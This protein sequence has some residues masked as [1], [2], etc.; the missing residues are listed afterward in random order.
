MS[1]SD[2]RLQPGSLAGSATATATR[3]SRLSDWLNP[4]L[5]REVKQAVK[6]R[7]FPVTVMLA[8][9]ISAGIKQK[10]VGGAAP[11]QRIFQFESEPLR[12]Q[13]PQAS[14]S[15]IDGQADHLP[16]RCCR[17]LEVGCRH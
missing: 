11:F 3:W 14:E 4:I 10:T 15:V 16:G 8:L 13:P 1:A 6:G 17:G 2:V 12:T 9:A 5:V 7:V